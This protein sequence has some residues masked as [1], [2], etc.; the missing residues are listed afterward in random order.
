MVAIERCKDYNPIS[1]A[2]TVKRIFDNLGGIKKYVNPGTKVLLKPNLI[3]ARSPNVAATTHP[4]IVKAIANLVAEAGGI[5]TLAD[6]PGGTYTEEVLKEVYFACEMD[7]A[8]ED[9]GGTLNYDLSCVEIEN[10]KGKYLK[11][12]TSIK[13]IYDADLIIN[14]PKLK[15]HGFMVYTGAVKNMF[16]II[17]GIAKAQYHLNLPSH[18]KFADALIDIYLCPGKPIINIMDAVIGMDGEGPT[19]GNPKELGFILGSEDAFILDLAALSLV[20]IPPESVPVMKNA[21]ERG[22]CPNDLSKIKIKGCS[23]GKVQCKFDVPAMTNSFTAKLCN[24][25]IIKCFTSFINPR[26]FVR[27]KLCTGCGHCMRNCPAKTIKISDSKAVIDLKNCI[28]CFCCQE[29]CPSKAIT[30]KKSK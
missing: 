15:S 8:L 30:I 27:K 14:I 5:V 12:I 23:I 9:S 19:A 21:I 17:P 22:L 20:G 2:E 13:P 3:A 10:P 29:L 16:G 24:S 6:S 11:K 25:R 28:R 18:E 26:P 7:K 4:S 1:V